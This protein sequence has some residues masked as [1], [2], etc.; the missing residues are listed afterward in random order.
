MNNRWKTPD[1]KSS[2]TQYVVMVMRGTE[3]PVYV[4]YPE[5]DPAFTHYGYL[6]GSIAI[7]AANSGEPE[8]DYHPTFSIGIFHKKS[9]T[10]LKAATVTVHECKDII[11]CRAEDAFPDVKEEE[12]MPWEIE[13]WEEGDPTYE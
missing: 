13:G 6:L 1:C 12:L 3:E 9:G 4:E 7:K 10:Y 2:D 8:N 5:Y 11:A